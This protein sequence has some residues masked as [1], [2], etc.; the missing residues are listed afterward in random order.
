[1]EQGEEAFLIDKHA[2]HERI[3]FDKLRSQDR[4]IAG[5]QL[6]TPVVCSLGAEAAATVLSNLDLLSELGYE[7]Q[8]FGEGTVL[9]RQIPMDLDPDQAK[10]SVT[11]LAEDLM[12]GRREDRDTLRDNLLHTIACKAAIKGGW[13]TDPKELEALVN[14]VMRR[15]DLK[16]CPHGRPI[17]VKLT[18]RQLEHRFGRG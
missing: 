11:Q 17:C 15:E 16:Y 9:L 8:E 4:E 12:E 18:R 3:L 13:H 1:M 14:T 7:A 5:Q 2:A 6:L 10:D